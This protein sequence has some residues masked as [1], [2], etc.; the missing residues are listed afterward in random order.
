MD[1]SE[2]LAKQCFDSLRAPQW[3]E[4]HRQQSH[5]E[6]DFAIRDGQTRLVGVLEVTTAHDSVYLETLNVLT[7]ERQT[8][9][10]NRCSKPWRVWPRRDA[11]INTIRQRLDAELHE[12]EQLGVTGFDLTSTDAPCL[13]V[14]DQLQ[15]TMGSQLDEDRDTHAI[16][17]PSHHAQVDLD[18]VGAVAAQAAAQPDNLKKLSDTSVHERHLFVVDL[19]SLAAHVAM[20]ENLPHNRVQVARIT[21]VWVACQTYATS[22]IVLHARNG[23]IGLA[24]R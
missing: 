9:S 1:E 13:R 11:C 16:H 24:T 3:L 8:V 15:L 5:G 7:P 18:S 21:D 19:T 20:T 17:L 12:L 2:S 10:V 23:A 14:M 6:P 22:A 4:Y